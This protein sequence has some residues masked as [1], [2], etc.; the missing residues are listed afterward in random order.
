M[1]LV[2]KSKIEGKISI[3]SHIFESGNVQMNQDKTIS[4][5]FEFTAD[6]EENSNKIVKVIEGFESKVQKNLSHIYE[7]MPKGF[8]K[9]L[10]RIVPV[11]KVKM[12]WN[13]HA[14]KMNKNLQQAKK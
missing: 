8:F 9:H 1:W 7:E 4:E 2:N 11:T 14:L 6:M 13:V 3:R 5:D 12:V 10:R